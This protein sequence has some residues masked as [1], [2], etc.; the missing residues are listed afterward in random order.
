MQAFDLGIALVKQK[1][2]FLY[3]AYA[4]QASLYKIFI[5]FPLI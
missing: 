1:P 3:F 2:S 5:F 4:G